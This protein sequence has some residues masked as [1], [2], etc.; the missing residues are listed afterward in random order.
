MKLFKPLI[1]SAMLALA[2]ASHA[3]V[4][5]HDGHQHETHDVAAADAPSI[6]GFAIAPDPE[7]G[8]I[9]TLGVENFTF[10][11]AGESA[12]PGVNAG[13]VHLFINGHDLGIY[14]TS[15]FRL[16]ELPFGPHDLKVVLSTPDHADYAINGRAI[17]ATTT[18]TVK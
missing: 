11:E 9:V 4:H 12:A 7:G 14:Y 1:L 8:F 16:E 15:V 6:T 5:A 13:H 10:L 3:H 2:P 17:A 18:I